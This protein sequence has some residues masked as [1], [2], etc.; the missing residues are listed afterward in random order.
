MRLKTRLIISFFIIILVP[1]MLTSLALTG[2]VY[3][4]IRS[5]EQQ[6]EITGVT[7]EDLSNSPK[8]L[9]RFTKKIYEEVQKRT[10]EEPALFLDIAYLKNLNEELEYKYSYLVARKDGEIYYTGLQE[11]IEILQKELPEYGDSYGN[12]DTGTYI[13][14]DIQALVKQVDFIFSDGSEG[15]IF[16]ITPA[17]MMIPQLKSLLYETIIAVIL[18]LLITSGILT[19]WIYRGVASP[20]RRLKMAT[21]NIKEGN[22]DFVITA[23]TDDEIGKLCV[24]FEE[25]RQRLKLTTE[26]RL[27]DDEESKELISNI[28]HDLKTPI[29]AVKGYVE[30]IMDGVAD[31]PEK[32]DRYIRTI[33]NKANEMDRLIN[34]LT[35]YSK[36]DTNRMPYTFSKIKVAN[37]FEDCIEELSLDLEAKNIE[38][39]YFNYTEENTVI[40]ADAE[41]LK[42]AINNIINN[43]VKYR[44]KERGYINIRIQDV[45]DFIQVEIEDNGKGIGAKELA[46]VFDRFYRTDTSR[47][48]SQGGS[49]IGL[50][51]V[52]KII[53]DHGGKIWATS[54]ETTGTV[55]HFVLRKYQEVPNNE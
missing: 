7:Y 54:K 32:M 9:S 17:R 44:D 27:R 35:F 8:L 12:S 38:V 37:Y 30:G 51:I 49:G 28:S 13:G 11:E 5:I 1:I 26:E 45:G 46:Y 23:D 6:F 36:I 42:R 29:T 52:K 53:D 25:M 50:S 55:I 21:Q 47:N 14:W 39:A 33:Y 15:T 19:T 31:S 16:I 41:Q 2:V 48:S 20:L 4:Q 43:S 18:I 22:L 40:I 10:S 34:E 3:F 24:D